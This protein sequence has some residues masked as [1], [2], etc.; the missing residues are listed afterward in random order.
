MDTPGYSIMS[1]ALAAL[2]E[3]TLRLSS[4]T[5]HG[6]GVPNAFELRHRMRHT[7]NHRHQR[8]R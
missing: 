7:E 5:Q 1:E 4:F 2:R 3:R 6:I 8:F